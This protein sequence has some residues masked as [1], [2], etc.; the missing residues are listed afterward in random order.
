MASGQDPL[1]AFFSSRR[2]RELLASFDRGRVPAHVAIIMDG[3]GRWAKR[4]GL[5]RIAGHRAGAKAL[6]EC[7]LA[8]LELK[9]AVLTVY[10]FSSENWRRPADEVTGLM[11]LFAEVLDRELDSLLEKGVRLR[12]IGRGDGLPEATAASFDRAETVTAANDRLNLVVA[13]DYGGR[14]EILGAVRALGREAVA[15][16]VEPDA[17]DAAAFEA[18]LTT[19]G[20]PDPDLLIRT[21]GEQR[22][23]N[24]LLWQMAYTELWFTATLWP[25]FKRHDLLRAVSDFQHRERR[26]G[27]R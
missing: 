1:H 10:S 17:I 4:R 25:D 21:S 11:S 15:G 18:H 20:I 13:L 7:I 16:A 3:N 12:V 27:G 23:S 8:A 6:R 24:F 22:I 9:I 14:D 5:P 2:D 26:F 19:V